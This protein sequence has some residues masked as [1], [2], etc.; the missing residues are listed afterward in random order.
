MHSVTGVHSLSVD[1]ATAGFDS[2]SIAPHAIEVVQCMLLVAVAGTNTN[3]PSL[4]KECGMHSVVEWLS[5]GLQVPVGQSLQLFSRSVLNSPA[6]HNV[7]VVVVAVAVVTV[8]VVVVT[9]VVVV[10]VVVVVVAVAVVTVAVVVVALVVV[11]VVVV[12][13][14]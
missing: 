8:A 5:S 12:V 7:G 13:V 9:L 3:S 11:V 1:P 10:V 6:P 4:Q 14:A 2:H